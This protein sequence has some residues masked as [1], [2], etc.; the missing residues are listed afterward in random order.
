VTNEMTARQ[1]ERDRMVEMQIAARGV[2]DPR[3]LDAMRQVPREAF[4]PEELAARAY[5]DTP[6]PIPG[7][8][9]ISQPYIVALMAEAA[10]ILPDDRVLDVG[11]GS[12]YAAAVLSLLAEDVYS[13]ER[14]PGLAAA[15][16]E[17]LARLGCINVTVRHGD[18][19]RGWPEAAPFDAILAA[20]ATP[21]VPP[22]LCRQLAI[23][24]RLVIPVGDGS[25][26]QRLLRIVRTGDTDYEEEDLGRVAFVPLV[27][28]ETAPPPAS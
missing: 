16:R 17:R 25:H 24:G 15:A 2:R 13:I 5:D 4:V 23:G 8:Q 10:T 3:V 1:R 26:G 20:A 21:V 7:G 27:A 12:G 6:L 19:S 22:D 9:T 28:G 11:T 18:G 14:D